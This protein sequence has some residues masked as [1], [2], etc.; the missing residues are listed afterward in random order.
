MT[1]HHPALPCSA[2]LLAINLLASAGCIDAPLSHTA[3]RPAIAREDL[4]D[5]DALREQI[6][7]VLQ[8]TLSDRE[9]NSQVH[10]AWQILHGALVYGREFPVRHND[11]LLPAVDW[12]LSGGQMQGWQFEPGRYG[13]RA[14]LDG[15]SASGQGHDDQWLAVLSQCNLPLDTQL[16]LYGE[17]PTIGNWV[18]Q[19]KYDAPLKEEFSWTL[20]GLSQYLSPDFDQTWSARDGE[21]W[22]L[23]RLMQFE[24]DAA[25]DDLSGA[26]CG[27]THRVIGM[28]MALDHY[29]QQYPNRQ[30]SGGWLAAQLQIDRAIEMAF[31]YQNPDGSFSATYFARPATN[32]DVANQL[33][34]SGHVLEFLALTLPKDELSGESMQRAVTFMCKLFRKTRDQDLECGA[35]YHAAHGLAIYRDRRWGKPNKP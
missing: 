5:H 9:L 28:S 24:A 4:P 22:N 10:A 12:V 23:E 17:T 13:P 29:R 2:L 18:A 11:Q 6:D 19:V 26:A 35:L 30:L 1:S 27:G 34:T 14:L 21:T 32:P 31:E 8:Y 15:G 20:I 7:E 16:K 3:Y 25:D 33:G